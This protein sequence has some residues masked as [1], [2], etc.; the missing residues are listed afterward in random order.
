MGTE[1]GRREEAGDHVRCSCCGRTRFWTELGTFTTDLS[2]DFNLADGTLT[3][4]VL[5]C[6][7][8]SGCRGTA[9]TLR[10]IPT[11]VAVAGDL[12]RVPTGLPDRGRE[13]SLP[14]SSDVALDSAFVGRDPA[15]DAGGGCGAGAR[16]DLAL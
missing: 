11:P 3:Q 6:R 16:A 5:Y 9:Q 7:D 12:C 1:G 14:R 2:L 13:N 4:T 8:D 10:L 15:P